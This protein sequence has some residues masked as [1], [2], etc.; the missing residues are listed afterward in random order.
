M[1]VGALGACL[2]YNA[3]AFARFFAALHRYLIIMLYIMGF[4]LLMYHDQFGGY[5]LSRSYRV[6]S[7]LFFCFIILEQC[8]SEQSFFKF[9]NAKTITSAGKYTYALY[10]LH[11]IGIQTAIILFRSMGMKREENA[12]SGW[13]YYIIA[14]IVSLILAI[15]SYRYLEKFFLEKRRALY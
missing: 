10:M 15:L 9:G 1:A 11:P 13:L 4:L 14:V 2:A 7:G 6:A 12:M 5:V 3:N 8:Y